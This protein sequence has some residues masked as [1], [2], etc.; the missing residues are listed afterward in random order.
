[1][2]Y[3]IKER[4]LIT[5]W[6]IAATGNCSVEDCRRRFRIEF[7]KEA[8]PRQTL[9]DWKNKLLETGSLVHQRPGQG[10]PK[11]AESQENEERVLGA[12]QRDPTTSTR[13]LSEELELSQSNVC[14]ILKKNEFH[15]YKPLYCQELVDGD[16]DRRRQFCEV[17]QNRFTNDPSFLRKLTFSDECVFHLNGQVNKHNVHF[18]STDNPH[19]RFRDPGQA[20]S[21]TVWACISFNGIIDTNIDTRTMNGER[22]C[23]IL[24]EKVVPYFKRNKQM[25]YQQDGASSHYCVNARQILDQEMPQQWIGRRGFIEWPARSPDLT[26]CDYWFWSYLRSRVYHPQN[27]IF[28]SVIELTN[29]I[30]MEMTAIPLKMFRDSFR[31]FPKRLQKCLSANGSLFEG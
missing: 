6:V 15:P 27:V 12:V 1:M 13:R 19:I 2:E 7:N 17:M 5:S 22:Y 30:Q 16:D 26:T 21:V 28:P 14:R 24:C 3:T 25:I 29:R 10:R 11:S 4:V 31:D 20:P 18:W 9:I 8:P 23:E